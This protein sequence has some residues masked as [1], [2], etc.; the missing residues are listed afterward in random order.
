MHLVYPGWHANPPVKPPDPHSEYQHSPCYQPEQAV[1]RAV[2]LHSLPV[3]HGPQH[4][5]PEYDRDYSFTHWGR[6][7]RG[8]AARSTRSAWSRATR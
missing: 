6:P 4:K 5:Q 8:R 1:N 3:S 7:R 2:Q